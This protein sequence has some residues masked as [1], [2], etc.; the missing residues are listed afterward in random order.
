MFN[1]VAASTR[2]QVQR[3]VLNMLEAESMSLAAI[4][5]RDNIKDEEDIESFLV[6]NCKPNIEDK[7]LYDEFYELVKTIGE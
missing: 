1:I 2:L 7:V 6:N 4:F 5:L 3:G